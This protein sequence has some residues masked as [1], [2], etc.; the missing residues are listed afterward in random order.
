MVIFWRWPVAML[1]HVDHAGVYEGNIYLQDVFEGFGASFIDSI[2]KNRMVSREMMGQNGQLLPNFGNLYRGLSSPNILTMLA[3]MQPIV[4]YNMLFE[5]KF[6]SWVNALQKTCWVLVH[7]WVKMVNSI[8]IMVFQ[9]PYLKY[10]S[11]KFPNM[12]VFQ[13]WILNLPCHF[14]KSI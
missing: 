10:H 5:G 7:W 1:L 14:R 3:F 6:A 9:N 12:T 2:P 13:I 8:H 11:T 4:S